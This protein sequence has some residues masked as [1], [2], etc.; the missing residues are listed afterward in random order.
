MSERETLLVEL[1]TEELPPKALPRLGEAFGRGVLE[2]LQARR[3]V[4]ADAPWRWFASPRRLAVQVGGVRERAPDQ[5]KEERLMPV[6]VAFD[7]AGKP[8]AA[9]E[10]RLAAKGLTLQ[11]AKLERR[12][13]GK[14]EM[15][16]LHTVEA[17]ARLDEAL[18]V[19]VA[20]AIRAL[21][22]PKLMR[23]GSGEA[24]FVRP[25]HR[26]V[27]LHGARV[28]PGRV[29]DLDSGRETLGH[30]FMSRGAIELAH[31]EAYEPT[32]RAEGKVIADFA[33]RRAEIERQLQEKAAAEGGVLGE[34]AALLDEV[35]ALVEH[36]TVYV[37]RF[38][39]EFLAVPPECLILTMQANQKY[40]PLF[41]AQGRLTNRF[42][43]VSN[44]HLS[45]PKS[46]N[47]VEGNQ[48]VVRPRLAD[49]RFFYE[50]D[51]KERLESRLPRL[52]AIVYHNRIG[53][54]G[55]RVARL[56]SLSGWL[57]ERL[58]ADVALARRAARLAKCDL[59]TQMVGEFPELQGVM[60]RY[61]ALAD[62]EPEAV[63]E[64]IEDHYKPRFAGDTLPRR[65]TGKIVALAERLDALAGLFAIGEIPTGEKDPYGLRR[66]ALGVLRIAVETPLPLELDAAIERALAEQPPAVRAQAPADTVEKLRRFFDERLRHWLREAGHALDAIDAV[67]A[68]R[69]GRI[70]TVPARLEAV[71]A[72]LEAPEAPTL[73]A[74]NKRIA[75]LLRKA[76][77][78]G[79]AHVDVALF[80]EP[81]EKALFEKMHAVAPYVASH[82]ENE[83][84]AQALST[85]VALAAPVDAF[86][87][88]VMV[89]CDEPLLRANRLALL[90]ELWRL[91]NQV[92]DLSVLAREAGA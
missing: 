74:A 54:L 27:L 76:G 26:L 12:I 34:H 13:E 18:A 59:V 38:E 90:R 69:P 53:T 82:L 50:Q 81:E 91:M 19:L 75:N 85:L 7:A 70:D 68:L 28:V 2:R 29:L 80:A 71:A 66:A 14:Q 11:N 25:V 92:A 16:Y 5:A 55:E 17:G 86:F 67:L 3:L 43:I 40:F 78:E 44:M 60:G 79:A 77:E 88:R 45:E 84:Y 51:R 48:R 20:E 87:D 61:Y 49:A 15:L 42:L 9:L 6:A 57:A 22:I 41:D 63:A 47:I 36:P 10:K 31:A 23:W 64:A 8:T 58:A 24:Q 56:E 39:E 1:V 89:L 21:P 52:D 62:G 72:F 35:T 32:L 46:R 4:D 73:A 33:E 65:L 37:G 30:R 83:A